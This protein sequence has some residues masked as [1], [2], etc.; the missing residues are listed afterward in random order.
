MTDWG[1]ERYASDS[2]Q[3]HG[4]QGWQK[5]ALGVPAAS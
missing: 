2:L 4:K 1:E 3:M 5:A